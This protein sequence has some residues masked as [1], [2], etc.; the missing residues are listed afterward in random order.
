MGRLDSEEAES[1]LVVLSGVEQ[2]LDAVRAVLVSADVT[3]VARQ[4]EVHRATAHRWV[5]R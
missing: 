5:G 2:R 3:E 1:P 4:V